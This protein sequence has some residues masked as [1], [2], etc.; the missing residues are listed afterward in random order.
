MI[1]IANAAIAAI[2][3][4]R[5]RKL[6]LPLLRH[7]PGEHRIQ[8]M[9]EVL[10]FQWRIAV[11]WLCGY[12]IFQLYNPGLLAYKGPV[13]A[14]Q[15]GMSLNVSNALSS[16]AIAWINTKAAPFGTMI[17]RKEYSKL[18]HLFFL[19]LKRASLVCAIGAL[20]VW[21]GA[22]Y[23]SWAHFS[24]ANRLLD[25]LSLG[26]LLLTTL[27]NVVVFAETVYLS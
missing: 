15:M 4:F 22:F 12:F 16:V 14:G 9:T 5:R 23:L 27:L 19:A 26:I 10:P 20:V 3:F 6:L 2:W 25:P 11:S 24:V 17:A 18:D 13:V 21:I 1:L 7:T 8:W